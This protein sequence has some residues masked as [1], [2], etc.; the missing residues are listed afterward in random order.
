MKFQKYKKLDKKKIA[1][2]GLGYVG[3]PLIIKFL[4][5]KKYDVIGID[6]DVSKINLL[7]KGKSYISHISNN[8]AKLVAENSFNL[9]NN[10]KSIK[11]ADSVIFTLP[12][13]ITKNKDPDM[14]YI[15]SALQ[16][17]KNYFTKNQLVVLESTVYPGATAD[18]FLPIFKDR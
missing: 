10:Y 1:I 8:E 4:N 13:P 6:N 7:K 15:S 2:I 18:Y 5:S 11:K 3:L 17:A 14:T 12:T 16:S 9:T